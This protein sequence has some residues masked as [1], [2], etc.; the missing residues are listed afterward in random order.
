MKKTRPIHGG[1]IAG[2]AT[3]IGKSV[4]QIIDFSSNI[5]P[6]G[7]PPSLKQVYQSSFS[8]V[9]KYPDLYCRE[10]HQTIAKHLGLS[11]NNILAGNG[12]IA[13]IEL[14]IRALQPKNVLLAE[15]CFTEYKRLAQLHNANVHSIYLREEDKF[16]F[17]LKQIT[18]QLA[19]MNLVILGSP[20]NPTGT[21][22]NQKELLSLI[23]IVEQ[24]DSFLLI[25]EAFI[26]WHP[27]NSVVNRVQPN[28]SFAVIRSLTKY[29]ALAGIRIGYAV[30]TESFIEHMQQLQETWSCNAVAQALGVAALNDIAF[31]ESSRQ[32]FQEESVRFKQDL[33]S[34]P[35]IQIFPGLVN[36]ILIKIQEKYVNDFW[37]TM[38]E[39]GIYLRTTQ[40]FNGLDHR[41]F[42]VAIR[43]RKEN[44]FLVEKFKECFAKYDSRLSVSC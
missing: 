13:L 38:K 4:N 2:F 37:N 1:D 41:Y 6:L 43:T 7:P 18:D 35:A 20:N 32:W 28:S 8:L 36:Y 5:N 25:D 9:T 44:Q 39:E 15:P 19:N 16:E 42:R 3:S 14:A 21:A 17:S 26:D 31:Q 34:I 24:R 30:G 12:A 11:T 22:L 23:Q 10:L 33:E 40:D 27:N 29:F